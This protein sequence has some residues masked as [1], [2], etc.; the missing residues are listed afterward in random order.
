MR[1]ILVALLLVALFA[2]PAFAS[3]F[4]IADSYTAPAVIP[5]YFKMTVDGGAEFQIPLFSGT[6][7]DG[8]VLQN[9]VH[10]DVGSVAVG[11]HVVTVKACK[12][13]SIWQGEV[14]SVASPFSFT[15]PAPIAP[16]GEITGLSLSR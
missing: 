9:T 12:V 10:Y 5:D 4:I 3:P 6:M 7:A 2:A 13:G 16:P 11:A 14:C 15:R 1:R 8:T